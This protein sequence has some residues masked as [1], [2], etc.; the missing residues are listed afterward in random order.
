LR[1]I[2]WVGTCVAQLSSMTFSR[3][4]ATPLLILL[5]LFAAA[6]G[7]KEPTGPSAGS[8]VVSVGGLPPAAAA[9]VTVTG[10]NGFSQM[11]G[12]SNA[13]LGELPP[14]SY[15]I[16]A[17]DVSEGGAAYVPL[18]TTQVAKVTAGGT[19]SAGVVYTATP[20]SL[21]LTVSG[22]PIGVDG[23]VTVT[24]PAGYSSTQTR[25]ASLAGLAPGTYTVAA[26]VAGSAPLYDPTP[27]TQRVT[28]SSSAAASA[29][30]GYTVRSA[31][32]MN[33]R[34]DGFY[35]T[36]SVQT[37]DRAI[38]L[39]A[40]RDGLL[41]VFV[42]ANQGNTAS[43]EVRARFYRAGALI[44]TVTIPAPGASVPTDTVGSQGAL[45]RAWNAPLP[46]SLLQPG[47]DIVLDVD[48]GNLIAESND[49]DNSYPANGTPVTL[50]LR[51]VA[52]L[53]LRL[54]PVHRT[55]DNTT[56][57][58]TAGNAAQFAD[59]TLRMHPLAAVNVDV[60]AA[61]TYTDTAQIQSG[62]GNGV[63]LRILSEINTLRASE[64][65]T[66]NYYGVIAVP[67]GGGIAGYGYVPGRTSVGWDKLPSASGVVAHEL[68]H[69][70][71]RSHAPCG[72][73]SSS[74]PSY[75]YSGGVTGA[76]GY[77]LVSGALKAPTLTDLM[78][79]CSN[80][81]ISDY[82][83]LG[84]MNQRGPASVVQIGS[85]REPSL[86][87]W[88]RIR[89]GEVVL[90]PA[91]EATTEALLPVS[92]G[93]NLL[94]GFD[95]NGDEGF[96]IAFAGTPVADAPHGEEHFAFAVPL[97]MIR[98]SLTRLQLESRGQRATLTTTGA[99]AA[100]RKS[101]LRLE[102][103]GTSSTVRWNAAEYPLAV[104]RD[105]ATGQILSLAHGG[106][107]TLDHAAAPLV[108]TLSDRAKS[109]IEHLQ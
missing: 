13:S 80:T 102:R 23:A 90:E 52:T 25:N 66:K 77:D 22:L 50:N 19:A 57:N 41:R 6:C 82:T 86:I 33:L 59:Q 47:L 70:F 64:G 17:A 3:L 18:P 12:P 51:T 37:Y 58:V 85:M 68:G 99:G 88:G 5:V 97:R 56:G 31:T 34:I 91:F 106:S 46:A 60:R 71:G 9:S 1:H 84:V 39:V 103:S 21:S 10:P 81:W 79:Y 15:T 30:V 73:V 87:V 48:P 98:G 62:D 96:R 74:D 89:D 36:Q 40:G 35:V 32:G 2:Q 44:Q 61:Y 49:G 55:A 105:A 53:D 92:S 8:L 26:G 24:G 94:Q 78:G 43:P 14:G 42:L 95:A 38:P 76:W 65:G 28:V 20:G 75:P 101:N 29:S 69:N 104:V 93:P 54:V 83:Y 109:R 108:V 7:G 63:W 45:N 72:G 16:T 100:G 27:L 67:Y 4:A 11:V 107:V